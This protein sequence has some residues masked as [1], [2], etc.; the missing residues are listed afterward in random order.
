MENVKRIEKLMTLFKGST[1]AHGVYTEQIDKDPFKQKVKGKAMTIPSAPTIKKWTQHY[2]G[3]L[4]LGV[5]PINE[6][7]Q[8]YWGALDIDGEVD[9]VSLQTN[10]QK[11]NL[12][13]V[14]CYSKSK[15]AHCFLFLNTPIEARTM[16]TILEEMS[17]KL[18]YSGCEIFPK[19][20]VLNTDKGDL[21]NWL[22][23]P[24][25][26]GTRLGVLLTDGKLVEQDIDTFLTYAY[27]K[28][29]D[30]AGITK[31]TASMKKMIDS[32]DKDLEGAPPCLQY[33]LQ[34]QG[35]QEGQRNKLLFNITV[36]CKKR[37]GEDFKDEVKKIYD[38]YCDEPLSIKELDRT[39]QSTGNKD[40]MYQ[41]KD[42]MLKQYCNSS[43]CVDRE[44]GIDLSTEI[45]TIKNAVRIL[46]NPIMYAVEVELDAGLPQKVY[47]DTDQLFSQE[48]FRKECSM[49]LHKTFNPMKPA[50][51]SQIVSRVINTAIN[52]DPPSDM[53]EENMLFSAL[54][55]FVVNKAREKITVLLESDGVFHDTE[56]GRIYF[57]LEDFRSYLQ[58][59]QI[60]GKELT[61]WKLGNKL[62]KL[63]VSTDEVD[64]KTET[65]IKR[66]VEV[67][68]ETKKIRGKSIYLRYV[69][70][71]DINLDEAIT[72]TTSVETEEVI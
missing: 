26:G 59:K 30:T 31:L 32:L 25:F 72:G 21:G 52:Q 44:H 45:K 17:S 54:S 64:F 12:P 15:S 24:Y 9:H 27:S 62:N 40:Y 6:N 5:V 23:M 2:N 4:G 51:W 65:R 20:D 10:I 3:E 7:N 67:L 47:V 34:T 57:K 69:N 35:I 37:F 46:S 8:C 28:R 55:D 66:K 71:D 1:R 13:L 38:K 49:Q 60:Y 14:C 41:C 56:Q 48:L 68:D 33:I 42:G 22:N 70:V 50:G 63:M 58:R 16:R 19:Q 53:S 61:T 29:L 36:Y 18:G 39:I 11:L 43:I